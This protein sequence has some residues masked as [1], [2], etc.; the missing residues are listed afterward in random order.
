MG[1][2]SAC[3]LSVP[4]SHLALFLAAAQRRDIFKVTLLSQQLMARGVAQETAAVWRSACHL[5]T[6]CIWHCSA[7]AGGS[8][9]G[10]PC[11]LPTPQTLLTRLLRVFLSLNASSQ[12]ESESVSCH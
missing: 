3:Y 2:Q 6:A 4:S 10:S 12:E 7:P 1:G 9:L 11:Q 8:C 5:Y